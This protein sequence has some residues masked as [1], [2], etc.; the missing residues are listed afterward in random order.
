MEVQVAGDA[1]VFDYKLHPG[2][3]QSFNATAL[4][5]RMG[6]DIPKEEIRLRH[7]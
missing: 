1:L 4:M 2:V 5:A 3:C 6:I 7:E